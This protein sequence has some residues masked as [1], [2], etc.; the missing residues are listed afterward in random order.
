MEPKMRRYRGNRLGP[1]A[2]LMNN[3]QFL[4]KIILFDLFIGKL[5]SNINLTP[6]RRLVYKIITKSMSNV[7]AI[8]KSITVA[9]APKKKIMKT[10][11]LTVLVLVVFAVVS[12]AAVFFY[13]QNLQLKKYTQVSPQTQVAEVVAR[14]SKLILL[15]QGETPTLASVSDPAALK[16]Q[17]FFDKAKKDDQVLIYSTAKEAVL[18]RPSSNMI[19][20]VA[21]INIGATDTAAS[22]TPPPAKSTKK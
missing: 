19:I 6:T 9:S 2:T 8:K 15:P 21:P 10:V 1:A 13:L 4:R 20:N 11:T 16:N 7:E 5:W 22:S 18:Y 17:P 3:G 12:G 14:V